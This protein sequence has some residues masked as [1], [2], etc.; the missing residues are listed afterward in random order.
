MYDIA[1][2]AMIANQPNFMKISAI[3]GLSVEF[4]LNAPI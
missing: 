3:I 1:A 4:E 2:V